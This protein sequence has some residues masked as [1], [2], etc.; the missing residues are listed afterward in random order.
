[1]SL[2]EYIMVLTSIL[3]GL[4]V[5]E[6]LQGIVRLLRSDFEEGIYLPQLLWAGYLFLFLIVIWWSR[7]DL[8]ENFNWSFIQLIL[9][10]AGPAIVFILSGLV[11]AHNE[12]ARDY[13]FSK[14]K[15]FFTL[16]PLAMAISLAHEVLIE[17]TAFFSSTMLLG[18]TLFLLTLIP[19]YSDTDWVNMSCAVLANVLFLGWV[20]NVQYFIAN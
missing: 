8:H 20:L 4:G 17:G 11:F 2:F 15:I 18:G 7:W 10:L 6:L 3:I 1:M 14:Q 16:L 5:A 12:P 9:S 13:Y 19:R